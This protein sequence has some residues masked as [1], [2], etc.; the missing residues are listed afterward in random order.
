[1]LDLMLTKSPGGKPHSV[2]DNQTSIIDALLAHYDQ[3]PGI[4]SRTLD[5]KFAAAKRSLKA[6]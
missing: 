3:K 6:T 5:D 2:F 1:M 4:S